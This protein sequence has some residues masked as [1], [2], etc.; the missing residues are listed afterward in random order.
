LPDWSSSGA[1]GVRD[2]GLA[3]ELL[4][5]AQLGMLVR[6]DNQTES[7][8]ADVNPA[9]MRTVLDGSLLVEAMDLQ[10]AEPEDWTE[11]AEVLRRWGTVDVN[12]GRHRFEAVV[13]PGAPAEQRRVK[14]DLRVVRVS[15]PLL[16]PKAVDSTEPD[17]A[18]NA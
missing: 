10:R 13:P 3:L 7:T 12:E 15:P 2:Q 6:A 14:I 8:F 16:S 9:L 11:L 4:E 17:Q 5:L 18:S 1:I